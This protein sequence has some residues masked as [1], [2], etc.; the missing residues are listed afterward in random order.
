M[1]NASLGDKLQSMPRWWLY[2]TLF[3]CTSVPLWFT[4][5]VPNKP[6]PSSVAFYNF[7]RRAPKGSTMLIAS[8]WTNSTRGESAG[9]FKALLRVLMRN[10]VKLAIY[11]TADPQAPQVA[12]DVIT[13]LNQERKAAGQREY[14]QWNDYVVVGFFPN[15][16]AAAVSIQ[17]NVRN[18]FADKKDFNDAGQLTPVLQSPVLAN[19]NKAADFPGLIVATASNTSN[20]TIQR[21]T[22]VPLAM[23]VTGV[24][25]PETNNYYVSGQLLGL[26]VG[27]KG[28]YDM[29]TMM[30][31]DYP[32]QKNLDNGASYYP[33][34]HLALILLIVAVLIGNIG[35]LM[36]RKRAS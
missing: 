23:M 20:I 33:T 31:Q 12:K 4:I 14:V 34:L 18:A 17:N 8:D 24:M 11:S 25:G 15:A 35:M 3:V 27:L 30:Q 6:S 21:V 9:Q 36:S 13:V 22:S 16:E 2:L 32:G 28:C 26:L 1:A 7:V 5:P 19:I 29:E 10:E